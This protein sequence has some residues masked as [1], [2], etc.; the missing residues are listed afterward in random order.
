MAETKELSLNEVDFTT[1]T[2]R[3]ELFVG[4][5]GTDPKIEGHATLTL[6]ET[7]DRCLAL[8]NCDIDV[9][10]QLIVTER[11]SLIREDHDLDI[12]YF[13]KSE[14]EFD[15][16]P[17]LRDAILLERSVKK[18]CSED[19]KGLCPRCGCSLNTTGCNC[20]EDEIDERWE[21]LKELRFL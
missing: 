18:I 11:E 19:C 6:R 4:R 15:L 1:S 5:A 14:Q 17:V 8:F 12:Y 16:V 9:T 10:F 21:V 13:P 20:R 3:L 7:C 2:F